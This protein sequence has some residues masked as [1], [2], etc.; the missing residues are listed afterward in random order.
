MILLRCY[1]RLTDWLYFTLGQH[2]SFDYRFL[3]VYSYGFFVAL[4]FL[5]AAAVASHEMR[6]REKLG[7]MR[8]V[9]A[10]IT[11]GEAPRYLDMAVYFLTGF[12]L[13]FKAAGIVSYQKLLSTGQMTLREYMMPGQ[14][15][16][17]S[18]VISIFQYGNVWAGLLGGVAFAALYYYQRNKDKLPKPVKKKFVDMP[19]NHL[20]DMVVLAAIF[21]VLG[22]NFFNYLENPDDYRQFWDDP[23]GS[24]F[25]GLSIYG[26]LICAAA[27]IAVYAR[28]KKIQVGYLFDSIAPGFILANG[29]GR[30]GCHVSGDGDW[31]ITN[32]SP[33]PSFI[34]QWLWSS[35]YEHNIID[36]GVPIPGCVEEHCFRLAEPAYPT[37]LY[38]FAMCF[39]IFLIL[40]ALRKRLTHAPFMLTSVFAVLIGIQRLTI[41]QLRDLS[42]RDTYRLPFGE[43]RQSEIIS[44][45]MITA[46]ITGIVFL[47]RKYRTILSKTEAV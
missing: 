46:G 4:G 2:P 10:E 17:I 29:I 37:P 26:G 21:G 25:S 13:L 32:T 22:S 11:V 41:E 33:K 38:E 16:I 45:L 9:E 7:L 35:Y 14:G 44:M 12:V 47:W 42:G 31:G 3:P 1:P 40:W 36:E 5:F 28:I 34:P 19:S 30:I 15:N 23:F 6:R 20:G 27:A 39:T 24:I 8:G 18:A 43:F